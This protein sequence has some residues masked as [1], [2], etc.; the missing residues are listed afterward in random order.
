MFTQHDDSQKMLNLA[1]PAFIVL[2]TDY[3]IPWNIF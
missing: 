2:W 3:F 1:W